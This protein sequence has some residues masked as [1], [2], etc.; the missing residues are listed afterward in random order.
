MSYHDN[1]TIP[2]LDH[3]YIKL[4]TS[5]GSDEQI[6]ESARMSTNKG[7]LGWEKYD[8]WEC[9]FP[10]CPSPYSSDLLG[11]ADTNCPN[12]RHPLIR[13]KERSHPG[14]LRLLRYLWTHKHYTP[15]EMAG[16]TIEV[17]APIFVFREWHRHRTQ[18]YNEMSARYTPLP[19][20]NY[21]PS[22]ERL[23]VIGG[24]NKQAMGSTQLEPQDAYSFQRRLQE[25]YTESE[26]LYQ[27]ALQ[28]GVP[29]ELAR[30]CLP[31]A[32][33]SRMRASAN[34]RNWLHF[35][36]L[37]MD[38]NAQWEIRQANVVGSIISGLFPRSSVDTDRITPLNIL[39]R[40]TW[41]L[42]YVLTVNYNE[43]AKMALDINHGWGM[44]KS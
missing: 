10:S 6:I 21:V 3:G 11:A 15:F 18:S 36:T 43:R 29:K 28:Y 25:S 30:L 12:C 27:T 22:I 39:G 24:S 44:R 14:D 37:R 4:I 5:W 19:D 17:Q 38:T 7:F 1:P 26:K 20:L 41:L 42:F 16:I 33:Y 31:V 34:L 13:N 35:L 9:V 8:L 2:I 40:K 23:L 32:R